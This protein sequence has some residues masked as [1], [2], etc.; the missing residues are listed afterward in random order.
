MLVPIFQ[1]GQ[2]VYS[3]PSTMEIQAICTREKQTLWDETMRLTN[4]QNVYV[5]LSDRLFD[6]KQ[7]LLHQ[8]SLKEN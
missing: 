6:M 1:K 8:M 4:P 5:D 2:Y 7:K 3:S